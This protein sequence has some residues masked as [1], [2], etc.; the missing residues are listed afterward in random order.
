[1]SRLIAGWVTI[2]NT[3]AAGYVSFGDRMSIM[4]RLATVDLGVVE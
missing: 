2:T 4:L 1:M 3:L